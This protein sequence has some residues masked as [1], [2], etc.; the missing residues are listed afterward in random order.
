MIHHH[1]AQ[2]NRPEN[3][4]KSTTV[5]LSRFAD[6]VK[7]ESERNLQQQEPAIQP[8]IEGI[9]LE[10]ACV[11]VQLFQ[12]GNLVQHPLAVAPPES[13]TGIVMIGDLIGETVVVAMQSHPFNRTA[14]AGQGSHEHQHALNPHRDDEAAVGDQAMQSERDP[15]HGHPVQNPEGHKA[16]PAPEPWQQGDRCKDMHHQ[17]EAGGSP[18]DASLPRRQWTA[19]GHHRRPLPKLAG[20]SCLG[21]YQQE[22]PGFGRTARAQTR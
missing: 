3:Q 19:G 4:S 22:T 14:L 9:A 16:L 18:L 20:V 17:H 1:E 10:I 13:A 21:G 12:S 5:D 6:P 2:W 15:Q 8:A 7:A 11:S